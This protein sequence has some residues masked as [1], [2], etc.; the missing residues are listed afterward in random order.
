MAGGTV[1][2][3]TMVKLLGETKC[4]GF[5]GAMNEVGDEQSK[6]KI[7]F[8]NKVGGGGAVAPPPKSPRGTNVGGLSPVGLWGGL[9]PPAGLPVLGGKAQ[10]PSTGPLAPPLRSPSTS[11]TPALSPPTSFAPHFVRPPLDAGGVSAPRFWLVPLI[12]L[13]LCRLMD[14]F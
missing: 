6:K 10:P 2:G 13:T 9:S 8:L 3:G 1:V 14:S 5:G 7:F 11:F 12:L 4:G